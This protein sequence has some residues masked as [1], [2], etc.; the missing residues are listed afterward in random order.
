M[1]AVLLLVVT[2]GVTECASHLPFKAIATRFLSIFPRAVRAIRNNKV[3]DHWKEKALLKLARLS[4]MSSVCAAGVIFGL[5]ALFVIGIRLLSLMA[6]PLWDFA[7]SLEG[8]GVAS[9]AA[10][11]YLAVRAHAR[12]F[13]QR[14]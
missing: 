1:T 3:S 6:P 11:L 14:R 10:V 8:I 9:G 2:I 13:L 7:M 12:S 4:L 5:V